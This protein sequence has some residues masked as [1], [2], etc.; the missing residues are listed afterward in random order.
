MYTDWLTVYTCN[1]LL[2]FHILYTQVIALK[3][4]LLRRAQKR[5]KY[6]EQELLEMKV[7]NDGL[8]QQSILQ[9]QQTDDRI[10]TAEMKAIRADQE[11]LEPNKQ[12]EALQNQIRQLA[13]RINDRVR[14][15]EE[16]EMRAEQELRLSRQQ[17]EAQLKYKVT[18]YPTKF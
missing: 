11:L 10:K 14:R 15:A 9:S 5:E 12:N 2:V 16:R 18:R 4:Q 6:V 8:Q 7:Q 3:T 13:Q 17:A 1:M